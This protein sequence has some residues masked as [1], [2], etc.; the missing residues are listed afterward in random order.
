LTLSTTSFIPVQNFELEGGAEF[1][2]VLRLCMINLSVILHGP[3]LEFIH[4][5]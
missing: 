2:L 5:A 4:K 3:G 1:A